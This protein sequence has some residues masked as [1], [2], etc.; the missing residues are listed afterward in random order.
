[1]PQAMDGLSAK[2]RPPVANR[3]NA[4]AAR[5]GW[6][7]FG[8]FLWPDRESDPAARMADGKTQ[9]RESVFVERGKRKANKNGGLK[10]TLRIQA[11]RSDPAA[12]MAD[13]I[14]QGRESVFA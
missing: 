13:G 10:P 1:L 6:P 4:P 3:R 5:L 11:K 2:P 14:T 9:G 8:Y 7:L 12:R